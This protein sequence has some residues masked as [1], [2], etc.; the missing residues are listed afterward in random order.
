MLCIHICC[1]WSDIAATSFVRKVAAG[2]GEAHGR[3]G[4]IRPRKLS[5]SQVL[6]ADQL[7]Q[8]QKRKQEAKDKVKAL[9]KQERAALRRK[10]R[11]VK[12]ARF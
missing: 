1:V 12:A 5:S 3:H 2:T 4:R 6:L 11:L 10:S 7:S 8:L 9:K